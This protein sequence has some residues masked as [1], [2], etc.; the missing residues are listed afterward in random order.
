MQIVRATGPLPGFRVIEFDPVLPEL[1]DLG[2]RREEA[3]YRFRTGAQT[4]WVLCYVVEGTTRIGI[5]GKTEAVLNPGSIACLPPNFGHWG[6]HG[7]EPKHY[8]LWVSVQ[9]NR[10]ESRHPEWRL[11]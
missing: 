2:E 9:L 8:L 5:E 4:H 11:F 3:N 6:Q 1:V 10:I 7:L